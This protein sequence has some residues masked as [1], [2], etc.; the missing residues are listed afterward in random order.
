VDSEQE[1]SEVERVWGSVPSEPGRSTRQILE[2]CADRQVDVLYLVGVDPLKDF[3][4]AALAERALS[5]AGHVVV[6]SLELGELEAFAD[7][8]LPAA[9]WA[10]REGT[11]TDWEGRPQRLSPVRPTAGVCRADW[12]IFA[13][14]AAA[15]GHDLGLQTLERIRAEASGLLAP[16]GVSPR[17]TAWTGT[18][19]PQ[20][21]GDLTL[22]TYHLLVDDGRLSRGASELASTLGGGPFVEVH[23]DDAEKHG[24]TDGG[25]ALV[26]TRAGEA[27]L[28]V[29]V[30]EHLAPGVLFVPFGQP[31][32]DANVL[33]SG[34]FST[35]ASVSPVSPALDET[36]AVG[37]APGSVAQAEPAEVAS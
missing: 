7:A 17:V 27:E 33:L 18:G 6:Q 10:E 11:V 4:D 14:L 30:T 37:R 19:R 2:A 8:F 13:G 1:R 26:R 31:G 28:P 32:L 9:A 22:A 5:N 20:R 15:M 24:L 3:P 25:R 12:E 16:R 29:R 21:L 34:G 36:D 23:P 35:S